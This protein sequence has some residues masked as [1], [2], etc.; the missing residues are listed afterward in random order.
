MTEYISPVVILYDLEQI[1]SQRVK[2][3]NI[4]ILYKSS[5]QKIAYIIFWVIVLMYHI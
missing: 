2:G 5:S 1:Q 4:E 3:Q